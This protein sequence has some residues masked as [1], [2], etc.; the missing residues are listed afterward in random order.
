MWTVIM[1]YKQE[2]QKLIESVLNEAS[3]K[4]F[5]VYQKKV[6]LPKY[7]V[8]VDAA[9]AHG[10]SDSAKILRQIFPDFSKSDHQS[11]ASYH[12]AQAKKKEADHAKAMKA[13]QKK[14]YGKELKV[15]EGP[16]ISG[17]VDPKFSKSEND[18]IRALAQEYPQ[19][20]SI[21]AGH[22]YA[23]KRFK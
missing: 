3:Y 1:S 6:K 9:Q 20:K 4:D 5:K 17:G 2:A 11:A 21:A 16:N 7:N 10:A 12:E 19:H 13:A 14:A 23:A 8:A 18:K 15:G 22:A